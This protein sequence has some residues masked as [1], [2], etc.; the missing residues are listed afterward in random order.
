MSREGMDLEITSE[1]KSEYDK[2]TLREDVCAEDTHYCNSGQA[3]MRR[4]CAGVSSVSTMK[5]LGLE[6][7][8]FRFLLAKK[9]M[10]L[11]GRE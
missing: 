6:F 3:V 7:K 8:A 2:N 1:N 9:P 4:Q 5:A 11:G 10:L